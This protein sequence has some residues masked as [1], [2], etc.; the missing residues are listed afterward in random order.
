[1]L[2]NIILNIIFGAPLWVWPLLVALIWIGLRSARG[3]R[4]SVVAV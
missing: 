3:R 1:M 4:T 2:L